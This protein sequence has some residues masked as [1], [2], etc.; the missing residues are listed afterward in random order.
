[1]RAYSGRSPRAPHELPLRRRQG[2]PGLAGEQRFRHVQRH[3]ARGILH[4]RQRPAEIRRLESGAGTGPASPTFLINRSAPRPR[5]RPPPSPSLVSQPRAPP[6]APAVPRPPLN[7]PPPPRPA[8]EPHAEHRQ[9]REKFPIHF[10]RRTTTCGSCGTTARTA[11]TC[12]TC[13]RATITASA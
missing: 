13:G 5:P 3:V 9:R 7:P 1:V 6:F 10:R 11:R 4:A 12:G 2:A 8:I